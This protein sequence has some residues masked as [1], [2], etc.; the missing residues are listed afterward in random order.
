MHPRDPLDR[1]NIF[2][3]QP[4]IVDKINEKGSRNDFTPGYAVP[5]EHNEETSSSQAKGTWI[6]KYLLLEVFTILIYLLSCINLVYLLG[7]YLEVFSTEKFNSFALNCP[8]Q[9]TMVLLLDL[10]LTL[11]TLVFFTRINWFIRSVC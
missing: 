7:L 9:T 11:A 10:I 1:E 2:Q 8:R 5:E 4:S 6:N 3:R